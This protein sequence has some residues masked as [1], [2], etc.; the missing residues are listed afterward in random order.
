MIWI[1]VAVGIVAGA[2]ALVG[3]IGSMLPKEHSVSRMAH[4]N[5]PPNEIWEAITDFLSQPSWR[6]DLRS[7]E[8]LP[9]VGGRQVWRERDKR[10]QALTMETVESLP[11]RRLVRRI[12]DEGLPFGGSWTMDI[13]E[14]GEVTSLTITEDGEVKNPFFRFAS[15]FIIGHTAAID[16]HLRALGKK[17]G[18]EVDA[19][20]V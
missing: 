19:T 18:V 10:G 11:P 14:Y 9:D 2:V 4:F 16:G 20:S 8:R 17:L 7:V 1:L 15:R 3:A 5:R 13:S 12:A 6:P